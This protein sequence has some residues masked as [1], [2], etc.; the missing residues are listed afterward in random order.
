MTASATARSKAPTPE[1]PPP[2]TTAPSSMQRPTS[3]I[4]ARALNSAHLSRC[5]CSKLCL[6]REE[7][8]PHG[9]PSGA[10]ATA[11]LISNALRHGVQ[12]TSPV[13][14]IPSRGMRLSLMLDHE[15]QAPFPP[16]LLRPLLPARPPV[17]VGRSVRVIT[18]PRLLQRSSLGGI[19]AISS[20]TSATAALHRDKILHRRCLCLRIRLPRL[21]TVVPR[22]RRMRMRMRVGIM[23]AGAMIACI[24][25]RPGGIRA[26]RAGLRVRSGRGEG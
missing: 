10:A 9:V 12:E 8:L 14:T 21:R 23:F 19:R 15:A 16:P 26:G 3:P 22:R 13:A 7:S 24:P 20:M 18:I 4:P 2:Q 17:R 25:Y 11:I 5:A 1:T 6:Q